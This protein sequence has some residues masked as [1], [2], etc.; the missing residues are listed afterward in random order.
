GAARL[1][2]TSFDN[3]AHPFIR[4]DTGDLVSPRG[5]NGGALSFRIREGRI[6]DFVQGKDGRKI[7]LTALLFGRHHDAFALLQHLQVRQDEPGKIT[8]LLV[9]MKDVAHSRL[10]EGFDLADAKIDWRIKIITEPIRTGAG[11]APLLIN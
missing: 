3:V 2:G 6:G 11:K 9:P 7:A 8:L 1:V 5:H 10:I 4:Y